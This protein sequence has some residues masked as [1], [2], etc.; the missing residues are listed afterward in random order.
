MQ[1]ENSRLK[2][3]EVGQRQDQMDTVSNILSTKITL[4]NKTQVLGQLEDRTKA[5]ATAT[6]EH[7]KKLE[8][9]NRLADKIATTLDSAAASASLFHSSFWSRV[10]L[11]GWWPFV[12]CPTASLLLGSY[13]LPPSLLRN[14]G[15]FGLGMCFLETHWSR[16]HLTMS[17]RRSFCIF[18]FS[19]YRPCQR[20]PLPSDPR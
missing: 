11:S 3:I 5:V 8:A 15:L 9:A 18:T 19:H 1:K 17:H 7:D 4:L 13:G 16:H 12:Y 20:S 2:A 10:G 6:E 14:V